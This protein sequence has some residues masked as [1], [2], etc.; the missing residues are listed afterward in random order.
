MKMGYNSGEKDDGFLEPSSRTRIL[1]YIQ[2]LCSTS[3]Y[4]EPFLS[5]NDKRKNETYLDAGKVNQAS[6]ALLGYSIDTYF[7]LKDMRWSYYNSDENYDELYYDDSRIFDLIELLLVFC[8]KEH[9]ERISEAF[10]DLFRNIGFPADIVS[11]M[12]ILHDGNSLSALAPLVENQTLKSKLEL[13]TIPGRVRDRDIENSARISADLTQLLYSSNES[14]EKTKSYA[15]EVITKAADLW[16]TDDSKEDFQKL[17]SDI[18]VKVK[19]LNNQ[20]SNVRHT[21]KHTMIVNSP[22]VFKMIY[23]L[24]MGVSELALVATQDELVSISNPEDIKNN[25][26]KRF[27]IDMSIENEISNRSDDGI[28]SLEDIPF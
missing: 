21:D 18:V 1:A 3:K 12:V 22:A 28:I 26:A 19:Q 23:S 8:K 27:D 24:N 14:Q 6:N 15:E 9:R 2:H 7:S 25:H 5:V 17:V 11:W 10:A 16:V 4:L 13:T 20:I